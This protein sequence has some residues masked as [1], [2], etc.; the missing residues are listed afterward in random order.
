MLQRSNGASI[1][2]ITRVTQWQP[3]TVRDF[4]SRALV[5]DPGPEGRQARSKPEGVDHFTNPEELGQVAAN[6]PTSSLV[7]LWNSL[8][9]VTPVKR[10]TDRTTAP[11][12]I[13]KRSPTDRPSP[14]R[15]PKDHTRVGRARR[16]P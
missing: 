2:E 14:L 1:A 9:G 10:L 8:P 3:H 7:R 5:H 16:S 13:W 4:I 12:R 11:N 6:W 15:E